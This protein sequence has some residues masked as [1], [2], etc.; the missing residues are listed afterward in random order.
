MTATDTKNG[1]DKYSSDDDD[2]DDSNDDADANDNVDDDDDAGE[3]C[4]ILSVVPANLS[5]LRRS[6][7]KE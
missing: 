3:L 6:R 1:N 2:D 7:P 5:S 4:P